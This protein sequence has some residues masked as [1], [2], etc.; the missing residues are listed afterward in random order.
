MKGIHIAPNTDFSYEDDYPLFKDENNKIVV[1]RNYISDY[2]TVVSYFPSESVKL[3][4]S[5]E[6]TFFYWLKEFKEI[7]PEYFV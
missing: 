4:S 6:L 5:E 7:N 2:N 1:M 3:I